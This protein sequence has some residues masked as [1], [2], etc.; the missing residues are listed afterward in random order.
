MSALKISLIDKN[1][2]YKESNA[3]Q[4]ASLGALYQAGLHFFTLPLS[5]DE[6]DNLYQQIKHAIHWQTDSFEAF[7]R[8]FPVPR[9]QAWYADN[10]LQYR[11]SDNLLTTQP[12]PSALNIL[13]RII[14]NT[15]GQAFNSVLATQYRNGEDHVNWHADNEQ[16]LGPNP[17]IASISFGTSRDFEFRKSPMNSQH[18]EPQAITLQHGDCL[19]MQ[20]KFQQFWQH[21]IPLKP[22][23]TKPRINLTFR[24]VI[25]P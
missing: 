15:T 22:G 9:L 25:N 6:F 17:Y 24:Q 1:N 18:S 10:N 21:K 20:P 19:L 16:E 4:T 5:A 7:G 14:E 12:W 23:E 13:R 3:T 2:F 11:Y 8:V